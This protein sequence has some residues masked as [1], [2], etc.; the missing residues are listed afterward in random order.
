MTKD[1]MVVVCVGLEMM[2]R[3]DQRMV[4]ARLRPLGL[5]AYGRTEKEASQAV[6]R[7]FSKMINR[8]RSEGVLPDR[9]RK[10]GVE[11]YWE[12]EYPK[13]KLPKVEYTSA[14]EVQWEK[15]APAPTPEFAMAA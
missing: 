15:A 6:K 13:D 4:V 12:D 7:L 2:Y 9:L 3:N 5:T 1:R 10:I 14:V 8:Y 11:W